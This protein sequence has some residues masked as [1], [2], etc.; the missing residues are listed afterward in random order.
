MTTTQRDFTPATLALPVEDRMRSYRFYRDLGLATPGDPADDGVPEPLK[1]VVNDAFSL[2][3][4]P[5]GGFGW[6]TAYQETVSPGTVECQ[7]GVTVSTRAEVDEFV[8]AAGAAG[9]AVLSESQEQAWG[10]CGVFADPDGHQWMVLEQ[11]D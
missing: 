7:V 1:V 8:A 3:L 6:V 11:P 4:V 10:Y 2:M 9:G 5:Y